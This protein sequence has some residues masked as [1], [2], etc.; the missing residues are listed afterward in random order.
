[1]VITYNGDT[2]FLKRIDMSTF[3][4]PKR[5]EQDNTHMMIQP[6]LEVGK[7]D[8][9]QEKEADAMADKVMRMSNKDEDDEKIMKMSNGPEVQ[10]MSDE[11]EEDEK[12]KKMSDGPEVQRMHDGEHQISKMSDGNEKGMTAPAS[13]EAGINNTKGNGQSLPGDIQREMETKMGADLSDVKVHTDGQATQM[14]KDINAKAFTHGQDI[15]F[16]QGQY[17][18]STS[19]GKHLLAHELTHTVQ[20]GKG[21]QRKVMRQEGD[22]F[23]NR[24]VINLSHGEK[25]LS[26]R[27]ERGS[28]NGKPITVIN[29]SNPLTKKD[30]RIYTLSFTNIYPKGF[31]TIVIITSNGERRISLYHDP[32]IPVSVTINIPELSPIDKNA[33]YLAVKESD[34]KLPLAQKITRLNDLY[35]ELIKNIDA[36]YKNADAKLD[37]WTTLAY[38]AGSGYSSACNNMDTAIAE[39]EARAAAEA[40]IWQAVVAVASTGLSSLGVQVFLKL[41]NTFGE[42]LEKTTHD[43][44]KSS[45]SNFTQLAVPEGNFPKISK[46]QPLNFQNHLLN[47]IAKPMASIKKDLAGF[48]DFM[49]NKSNKLNMYSDQKSVDTALG[50]YASLVPQTITLLNLLYYSTIYTTIIPSTTETQFMEEYERTMWKAWIPGLHEVKTHI[51]PQTGESFTKEYYTPIGDS[52]Q[53]RLID[54]KFIAPD[55]DYTSAEWVPWGDSI[56][57][58]LETGRNYIPKD[59]FPP[60]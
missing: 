22:D 60:I 17:N 11:D 7:K 15:Y 26:I 45:A 36:A 6:Q 50:E 10:R 46:A 23:E 27:A 30:Q 54:L 55:K 59:L 48:N 43:V 52:V 9:E 18:P 49:V 21:L 38:T 44:V 25:L 51:I 33:E 39:D 32:M 19:Q 41:K 47:S 2:N 53:Q 40:Q 37:E 28:A 34:Y 35:D 3:D 5:N 1:M 58:L 24:K 14:N 29:D 20:Q 4:N 12:F 42:V 13:V 31:Y 8:D 16:N 57:E 56:K